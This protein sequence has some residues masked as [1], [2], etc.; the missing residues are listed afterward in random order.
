MHPQR[1]NGHRS[2]IAV[3]GRV[4]D[5]LKVH[6]HVD[7]LDHRQVVVRLQDLFE[8]VAQAAVA[9]YE[10]QAPGRQIV[11]VDLRQ[12]VRVKCYAD[13]VVRPAPAPATQDLG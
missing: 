8:T 6:G 2:A 10:I 11:V 13:L 1:D 3:V 4:K 9:D 5:F 12:A 7:A